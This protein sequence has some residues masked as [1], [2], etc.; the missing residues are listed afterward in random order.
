MTPGLDPA[1]A[2]SITRFGAARVRAR[3][4]LWGLTEVEAR[5]HPPEGGWSVA[6]CV[7]HLVVAGSKMAAKLAAGVAKARDEGRVAKSDRPARFGWFDK[8]F[9]YATEGGKNG[10]P[11]HVRVKHLAAFD[12]GLGG[13]ASSANAEFGAL[14]DRL[15]VLAESARG[16]DL[17]GIKVA[18]VLDE[19]IKVTLG[20]WFVA[21]AGH[22]ERHLDQAERARKAIGR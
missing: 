11:P 10:K 17:S 6:Q 9:I 13:P 7:D 12:P 22:Q 5:T 20:A 15:I 21:I 1:L 2:W 16:L 14:Q 8:M 3:D 4:V 18:S 19:R